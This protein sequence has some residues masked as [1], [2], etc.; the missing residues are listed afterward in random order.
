MI[1]HKNLHSR[2]IE[3]K[4]RKKKT[5]LETNKLKFLCRKR[6]NKEI[7]RSCYLLHCVSRV[8]DRKKGREVDGNKGGGREKGG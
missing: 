1:K 6:C 7:R 3:K 5:E 8:W 4:E 2:K